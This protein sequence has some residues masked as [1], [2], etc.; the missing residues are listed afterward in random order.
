MA[1]KIENNDN[2]K[3]Q[4]SFIIKNIPEDVPNRKS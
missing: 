4:V 3:E 2:I 1:I